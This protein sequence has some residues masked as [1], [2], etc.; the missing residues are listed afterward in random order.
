MSSPKNDDA[1]PRN[2]KVMSATKNPD[3]S[4]NIRFRVSDP[5]QTQIHFDEAVIPAESLQL[6]QGASKTLAKMAAELKV[7][8]SLDIQRG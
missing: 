2:L 4:T 6:L 7:G 8:E 1:L 3:G 5:E